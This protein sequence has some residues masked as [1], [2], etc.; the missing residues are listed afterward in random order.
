M[1]Q[2]ECTCGQDV[3]HVTI[4]MTS[5]QGAKVT[6]FHVLATQL[7]LNANPGGMGQVLQIMLIECLPVDFSC[8]LIMEIERRKDRALSFARTR[9]MER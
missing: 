4:K 9:V 1:D 7:V 8:R 3:E 2:R 5:P 6:D